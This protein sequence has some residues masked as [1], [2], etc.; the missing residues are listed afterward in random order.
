MIYPTQRPTWLLAV[1]TTLAS[2]C[3]ASIVSAQP[4][5]LVKPARPA[6][7]IAGVREAGGIN[8]T[9]RAA[10][11]IAPPTFD[12]F[13][14]TGGSSS[15]PRSLPVI[16]P[17]PGP[18]GFRSEKVQPISTDG[19]DPFGSSPQG[20]EVRPTQRPAGGIRGLW[21]GF[22]S[23]TNDRAKAAWNA[24][25]GP[26]L[27]PPPRVGFAPQQYPMMSGQ[28]MPMPA[29]AYGAA[30]G[31]MGGMPSQNFAPPPGT[32]SVM[33][34]AGYAGQPMVNYGQPPAGYARQPMVN[35]G[36]PPAGYAAAP[37][38][39]PAPG[40]A[41]R[42]YSSAG[43]PAYA[44]NP[45]YRWY[46]W[47]T[48]TPGANPYS[49][50]GDY[51]NTSSQWYAMSGATPGA[52][53][54]PVTN[55]F[56]VV[57][58]SD[59]PSYA[60]HQRHSPMTEVAVQ[61]SAPA[62]TTTAGPPPIAETTPYRY[63]PPDVVPANAMNM[64]NVPAVPPAAMPWKG[65][66]TPLA[67]PVD[68]F[69]VRP[70]K[71]E[72]D[73]QPISQAETAPARNG[74]TQLVGQTAPEAP[75]YDTGIVQASAQIPADDRPLFYR[76]R[77]LAGPRIRHFEAKLLGERDVIIRYDAPDSATAERAAKAL[78]QMPDLKIYTLTFDVTI[79]GK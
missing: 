50:G 47:G 39:P 49:P 22:T 16:S 55:P 25:T 35:Y 68:T 65:G 17:N 73:W 58:N 4:V 41:I 20:N 75:S 79:A 53:P 70:A 34:P 8:H 46:G 32:Y 76:M 21:N 66:S 44:G 2:A 61:T 67:K 26:E 77:D 19:F 37:V 38:Q 63:V 59:A 29:T 69:P 11:E 57:P 13:T 42:G 51:P 72:T 54:I 64:P 1:G 9:V 45:A 10:P 36:Q 40:T 27:Q 3:S 74:L 62:A 24:V 14:P 5:L 30:P 33:P 23:W 52:F 12:P 15:S 6:V 71:S 48:T 28:P 56:R 7:T 60:V 43:R 18:P 31:A 78:S